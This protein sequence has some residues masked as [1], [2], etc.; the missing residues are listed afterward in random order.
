MKTQPPIESVVAR[1]VTAIRRG[2]LGEW[3]ERLFAADV[4]LEIARDGGVVHGPDEVARHLDMAAAH[5]RPPQSTLHEAGATLRF[6]RCEVYL[7]MGRD[8]VDALWFYPPGEPPPAV[9]AAHAD[10]DPPSSSC[11]SG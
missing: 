8:R 1:M 5:G 7:Q 2:D 3:S 4:A 11:C 6:D 9:R 10:E